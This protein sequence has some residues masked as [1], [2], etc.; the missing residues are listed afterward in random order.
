MAV[1]ITSEL[2]RPD[3]QRS[4]VYRRFGVLSLVYRDQPTGE[5]RWPLYQTIA[6][7]R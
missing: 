2:Y 4:T 7:R 1:G 6:S 5:G 3:E